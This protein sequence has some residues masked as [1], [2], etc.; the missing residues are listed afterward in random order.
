MRIGIDIDDTITNSYMRILSEFEKYY[1]IN[2]YMYI[3]A[4]I[5]YYDIMKD[6]KTFPDYY[7]YCK[8]NFETILYDVPLKHNVKEVIDK[9]KEKHEIIFITA[10]NIDEYSN[11]YEYTKDYLKRN[12][13]YYDELYTDVLDKGKLCKEK[14]IDVFIDDAIT[15]CEASQREGI[16]TYL[17]DNTFNK[18]ETRFKR[19]YSWTDALEKL[20]I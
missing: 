13:I 17:F 14:N 6:K 12:N 7:D 9:L 15:H 11:P 2:K 5:N 1:H 20:E 16:N 18:N 4:H 10:R 19:I 3:N 8:N